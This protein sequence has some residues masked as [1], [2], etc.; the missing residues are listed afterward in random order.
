M[1][2]PF[3]DIKAGY[4]EL[5]R[6][7]DAAYRR[8]M[9]SGWYI[10][11]QETSAFE[12]E[13]AEYCDAAHC[14]GV[15]NGLDALMLT[16][17][18]FDIG[19]GD[20]VIVPANTFIATWLAV[21][22]VGAK[23]VA[24]E[25]HEETYNIDPALIEVAITP[26]TKAIIPVHLYGQAADMQPI[27]DLAREHNLKVIEDA[28]Q[29]HGGRYNGRRVGGL[30]DAAAFSFY[31]GK[32]LGAFGDGGCVVTN[33][34]ALAARL[35]AL[36]NYGS[37]IKYVHDEK[38]VNSRLD[39]MQAAFLR[40]KLSSLDE[41]NLRRQS[42]AM[43]YID[44]LSDTPLVL[45]VVPDFAQPVWHLFV[46]RVDGRE[47][48][49]KQL[50]GLGVETMVHY[51]TQPAKQLAYQD[52]GLDPKHYPLAEKGSEQVLSLPISPWLSAQQVEHVIRSVK[53]IFLN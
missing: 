25:S 10:L 36:R 34:A 11:G 40:V 9:D 29:A 24:V 20:E 16:L 28:A 17:R 37:H 39:E 31:P 12:R 26:R 4:L 27:L 5:Q 8:V 52:S 46:V 6:E 47:Q 14:I 23:P 45:P 18:A 32:N 35:R 41:W 51:P 15:A 19:P 2:V 33:D 50:K 13:F 42:I 1:Q 44:Q 49:A 30:G 22:Y 38:G 3:L 7:L 21:S 53:S 43:R 48:F